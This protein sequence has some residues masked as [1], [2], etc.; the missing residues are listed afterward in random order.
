MDLSALLTAHRTK[1]KAP[2]LC[3]QVGQAGGAR[4]GQLCLL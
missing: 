1:V 2:C 3:S 4:G